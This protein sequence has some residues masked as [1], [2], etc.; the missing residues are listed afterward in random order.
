MEQVSVLFHPH[1]SSTS[2]RDIQ[3]QYHPLP[4]LPLI[5]NLEDTAAVLV[6]SVVDMV[7]EVAES[8]AVSDVVEV[9]VLAEAVEVVVAAHTF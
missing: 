8:V 5:P 1:L 4:L 7:K 6:L 9:E 3:P 2:A